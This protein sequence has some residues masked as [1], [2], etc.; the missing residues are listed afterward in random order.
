M[1]RFCHWPGFVFEFGNRKYVIANLR[2]KNLKT[3]SIAIPRV[4][5]GVWREKAL[6]Q[7]F[8]D[9]L[10]TS[11]LPQLAGKASVG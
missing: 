8:C 11:K 10:S 6:R 9:T 2:L 7:Q 3:A 4:H 1:Q 5:P